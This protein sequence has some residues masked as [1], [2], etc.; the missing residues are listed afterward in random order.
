MDFQSAP[1]SRIKCAESGHWWSDTPFILTTRNRATFGERTQNCIRHGCLRERITKISVQTG[2]QI[3][4]ITYRG[5]LVRMGK[6]YKSELRSEL[7]KRQA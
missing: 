6:T 5:R 1:D 3:G 2:E 4:G 7:I